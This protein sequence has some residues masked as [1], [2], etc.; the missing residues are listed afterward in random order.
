MRLLIDS[1]IA[2]LL[3]SLLAVVILYRQ[4][5]QNIQRDAAVLQQAVSRMQEQV[6]L[7]AAVGDVPLS[8]QGFPRL[9]MPGW[10]EQPPQNPLSTPGC[11]WMDIAPAGDLSDHPP[12]PVLLTLPEVGQRWNATGVASPERPQAAFWYNPSRGVVRARVPARFTDAETLALYNQVNGT[13]LS[14]MPGLSQ[15]R[16]QPLPL[17]YGLAAKLS[18]QAVAANPRSGAGTT[19]DAA[20]QG[21]PT[22]PAA[23]PVPDVMT[24]PPADFVTPVDL[25]TSPPPATVTSSPHRPT[26]RDA[27]P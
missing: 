11:D 14:A 22:D 9:V 16:H 6:R 19:H 23:E 15:R 5:G 1:M 7:Q 21:S 20:A 17:P 24:A 18:L 3:V 13:N 27:R 12:D 8:D 25:P 10:F 4:Q 2:L 26:L